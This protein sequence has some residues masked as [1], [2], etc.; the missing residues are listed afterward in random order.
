MK[1]VRKLLVSLLI[2]VFM[3]GMLGCG[4]ARTAGGAVSFAAKASKA[5]TG[6]GIVGGWRAE[7][8]V[9]ALIASEVDESMDGDYPSFSEYLDSAELD[10]YLVFEED[11]SYR[12]FANP[13]YMKEQLVNA[14]SLYYMD[15]F[16]IMA[17]STP[18]EEEIEQALGT[19]LEE[20]CR[21]MFDSLVD[22]MVS[23]FDV[24]GD[25]TLTDGKLVLD[26]DDESLSYQ[27]DSIEAEVE[28]FGQL[29]FEPVDLSSFGLDEDG[30]LFADLA[31]FGK[32]YDELEE[33]TDIR[34]YELEDFSDLGDGMET[35]DASLGNAVLTLLFQ[36]GALVGYVYTGDGSLDQALVDK[37]NDLYDALDDEYFWQYPGEEVYL[38][39]IENSNEDGS[40]YFR[41]L[42]YSGDLDI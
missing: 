40:N 42:L 32:S 8:D 2:F 26:D 1:A 3:L 24:D 7:L 14:T 36:N 30:L 4:W 22:E 33:E 10:L 12:M 15:L 16:T 34:L 11:G 39:F 31:L 38:E 37:A 20:Y 29:H 19:S 21:N 5:Q 28:G 18:T 23:E 9:G 13:L 17:G 35:A 6:D 27:G 25:Y 41:Q